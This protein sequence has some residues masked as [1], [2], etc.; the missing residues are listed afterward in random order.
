MGPE[1]NA[2][3]L[4]AQTAEVLDLAHAGRPGVIRAHREHYSFNLGFRFEY[5]AEIE[6]GNSTRHAMIGSE[7]IASR[8]SGRLSFI[9][10]VRH[11]PMS[12]ANACE[13]DG[14]SSVLPRLRDSRQLREI[15]AECGSIA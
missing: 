5:R 15:P 12:I 14:Q 8:D 10:D 3:R 6:S 9:F 1:A 7:V 13:Q 2:D 4:V 11:G